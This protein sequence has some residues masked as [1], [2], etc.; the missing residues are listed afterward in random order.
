MVTVPKPPPRY[1]SSPTLKDAALKVEKQ[2]PHSATKWR[3][4]RACGC[5]VFASKALKWDFYLSPCKGN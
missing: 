2:L 5:C 1:L 4:L 3:I